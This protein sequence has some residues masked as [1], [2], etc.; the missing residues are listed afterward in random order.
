MH[1]GDTTED[2]L[3]AVFFFFFF[4]AVFLNICY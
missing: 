3:E 2:E 4:E 1:V